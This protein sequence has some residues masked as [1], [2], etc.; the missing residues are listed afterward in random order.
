MTAGVRDVAALAGV[1]MST[2]SNVLNRPDRVSAEAVHRVRAAIEQLGFVRNDAA[3]QLRVGRSNLIGLAVI[4]ISNPFFTDVATGV[5]QAARERG[6]SVLIGSSA[7]SPA[8]ESASLDLFESQRVDGV[9]ILPAGDVFRELDGLRR[10]GTPGVLIDRVDENGVFSSVST[11][12]VVG[13]RLAAEH[14][15]GLGHRRLL[16]VGGSDGVRQVRDRLDGFRAV[17]DEYRDASLRVQWLDEVDAEH[18]AE[19]GRAIAALPAGERPDAIF[20]A[21]DMLALGIIHSLIGT[22]VRVPEHV[23]IVGYDDIVF[24]GVAAIP[25][26]SIRQPSRDMGYAAASLLIEHLGD[27]EKPPR[28]IR[29]VPELMARS[30]TRHQKDT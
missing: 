13:G 10:R 26:T 2:V 5:E 9:L 4:N 25:L 21:N 30:S 27:A 12:N 8:G 22:E 18:G 16:F 29:Y 17:V 20:A 15:L 11:D 19:L 1:S 28:V 24:A 6:Y 14:L 7:S 3:R 23:A